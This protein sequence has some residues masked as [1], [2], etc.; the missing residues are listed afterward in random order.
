MRRLV[1]ELLALEKGKAYGYHEYV[2]NLLNYFYQHNDDIHYE[3]VIIW[4]KDT[5]VSLFKKFEDSFEIV[6]FHFTSYV[7]RFWLQTWLPAKYK[8]N[9]L[10]LVF[11]PGNSSGL[12]KRGK[13]ILTVHDLL[14][15]RKEWLPNRLMRLQRELCLPISIRT[16]DKIV[17]IS[18]FTKDD[19]E[20]YYPYAKGKVEVIYN[21]MDFNK[22]KK[23]CDISAPSDYFLAVCSNDYHKNL[24][25]I[26]AAFKKYCEQGGLFDMV[27]I[28]NIKKSNKTW[29][30]LETF[31]DSIKNRIVSMENIS[32]E[33]LGSLYEKASCYISASLF[34]GLGMPIVEAMSF[35]IPVLLS[36]IPPHR[37][38][39]IN[40]GLYFIPKDVDELAIKMLEIKK[41]KHKYNEDIRKIFS[42][43]NTSAKYVA[44]FNE[45][46]DK[47]N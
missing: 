5:E 2:F 16:A 10:D 28:G 9:A 34:E 39:S 6:G 14:F 43:E 25:T 38:V 44:L 13:S 26:I 11:S 4:C 33:K 45:I 40:K 41:E 20:R 47:N 15:K 22:F 18:Q 7:K 8:L 19:L 23:A 24:I 12:F 46:F 32:N 30:L 42:E 29:E 21:S 31:P 36:D 35:G 27:I 17:A 37:E 1:I 3:K